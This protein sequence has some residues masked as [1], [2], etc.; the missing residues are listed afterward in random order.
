[1][2]HARAPIRRTVLTARHI[3]QRRLA[4]ISRYERD[5]QVQP[6]RSHALPLLL[7]EAVMVAEQVQP[8]LHR[9]QHLVDLRLARRPFPRPPA[10]VPD[11]TAS[12]P[13]GSGG[14]RCRASRC[15]PS[16][17]SRTKCRRLSACRSPCALPFLGCGRSRRRPSRTRSARTC[18]RGRRPASPSI[19]S[20]TVPFAN[21]DAGS[22]AASPVGN[23]VEVLVVALD[24]V[25]RRAERLVDVRHRPRR[26]RRTARTAP[27]GCRAGCAATPA[28]SPWMSPRR[29]RSRRAPTATASGASGLGGAGTSRS[30]L[31]QMKSLLL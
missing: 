20:A 3:D 17:S 8:R 22:P 30:A 15:T 9:R 26:H 2:I 1:M 10:D 21:V 12:P 25:D 16:T 28:K 4:S 14:C 13:R 7:R 24:P 19:T 18:R 6:D 11:G 29:R 31:S 23:R 5:D 27:S